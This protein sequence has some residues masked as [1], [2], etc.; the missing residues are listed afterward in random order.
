MYKCKSC[1]DLFEKKS[2]LDSHRRKNH[3]KVVKYKT[4]NGGM[5]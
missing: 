5:L 4:R 1:S 2:Q 3:Q